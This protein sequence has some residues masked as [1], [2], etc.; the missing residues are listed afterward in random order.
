MDSA[1][2]PDAWKEKY[3]Y[4]Y[5]SL[6]HTALL[7]SILMPITAREGPIIT[8]SLS[9]ERERQKERRKERTVDFLSVR[10]SHL[11]KRNEISSEI[12][13]LQR[14]R[15]DMKQFLLLLLSH[16]F[17]SSYC[18][19]AMMLNFLCRAFLQSIP[20]ECRMITLS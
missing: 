19:L 13:L 4:L 7:W 20:S 11:V 18:I 5:P 12:S 16:I 14:A 3:P 6:G 8:D 1:D 2:L 9:R 15:R 10:Q 17:R